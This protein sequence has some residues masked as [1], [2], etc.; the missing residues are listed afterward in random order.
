MFPDGVAFHKMTGSGNDF[1]V[2]DGRRHPLELWSPGVIRATCSRRTGAGADGV[3]VLEP[4]SRPSH[5]R[6]HYFNADGT[7]AALCGNAALCAARIA[8]TLD[9]AGD[10]GIVLETDTGPVP[11]RS[12]PGSGELAEL[13]LPAV[14]SVRREAEIPLTDGETAMYVGTVGVPHLVVLVDSVDAPQ[15]EPL[16]RGRALRHHPAFRPDGVNVNFVAREHGRWRLRTYERGVEAETLACGTGAVASAAAACL[17]GLAGMP[18]EVVTASGCT[19]RVDGALSRASAGLDAP[20]LV[21]EGRV[22]FSGRFSTGDRH[23]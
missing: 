22:V 8:P 3:V 23:T 11:A 17:E 16:D 21:G 9:L 19:L 10:G 6:M 1:V 18:W 20:K 4:G 13:S 5:V 14:S 15:A 7:R 12:V 2:V